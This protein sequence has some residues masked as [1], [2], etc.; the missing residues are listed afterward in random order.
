MGAARGRRRAGGDRHD[1]EARVRAPDRAACARRPDRARHVRRD[2]GGARERASGREVRALPAAPPSTSRRAGSGASPAVASTITRSGLRADARSSARSRRSRATSRRPR[3]S[4]TPP[5]WDREHRFPTELFPKLAELGL[6]GVCVPE[7]Y[8]G[9]GADFVSYILVL[10]ELSRA[11]AGVGRDRR[12]AHERGDAADPRVRHRR[13]ARAVRAAARARRADR[14]VRADRAGGRA[15]TPARCARRRRPRRRLADHRR[16]AVHHDRRATPAR[17]SSSRAPTRRREGARRLGLR[18][19]RRPR[20][21]HARGGEA[22]AQLVDRPPTSWSTRHVDARPA[23]A[24][25]GQGIPV[26][27]STLDGGRIGI[28]AQAVG[29]AQAAFDAAREL[30]ARAR[31]VRQRDRASS[32][33]SSASSPTC[34]RRSTRRACSST[35]PRG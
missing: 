33:R 2:H 27:M 22:R 35:G 19:R 1:R 28:A 29:I 12:R 10:E 34:R 9:A 7:E 4:R 13:A 14:R 6:M 25:G 15:R 20:P 30:R 32:R 31:A 26:A 18:A 11:D 8:G 16:E 17:F 23:P 5:T 24:R 3:S 21:R